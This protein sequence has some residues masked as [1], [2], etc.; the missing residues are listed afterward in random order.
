MV[1]RHCCNPSL[2]LGVFAK[3]MAGSGGWATQI[4]MRA[5]E[6]SG[7]WC[8]NLHTSHSLGLRTS[9][10]ADAILLL[11]AARERRNQRYM[12]TKRATRSLISLQLPF[13]N[14]LYHFK[15]FS[16]YLNV[17]AAAACVYSERDCGARCLQFSDWVGPGT[18][19]MMTVVSRCRC[20]HNYFYQQRA[21]RVE[22]RQ[23]APA[24]VSAR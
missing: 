15:T 11:V 16:S 2:W 4:W 3:C 8:L 19:V 22:S 17:N 10:S 18:F 24:A 7:G 1:S 5:R 20:W 21:M 6:S 12:V 14:K 13:L 23:F 9:V